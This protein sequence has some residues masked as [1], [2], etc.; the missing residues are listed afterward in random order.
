MSIDWFYPDFLAQLCDSSILVVEYKGE[1]LISN[2][3]TKE[4]ANTGEIWAKLAR[5]KALFMLAT[6]RKGGK[7][8][9]EQIREKIALYNE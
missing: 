1:N 4:K 8:L 6:I 2:D 7:S 9:A 3:D 5:G